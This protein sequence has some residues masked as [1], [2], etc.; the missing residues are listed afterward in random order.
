[1]GRG[2]ACLAL[3]G[4]V[5]SAL[6]AQAAPDA[7]WGEALAAG[8]LS[9]KGAQLASNRPLGAGKYRLPAFEALWADWRG[10]AP[11]AERAADTALGA[12]SLADLARAGTAFLST[13]SGGWGL[14]PG[15]S[16]RVAWPKEGRAALVGAVAALHSQ[17]LSAADQSALTRACAEVPDRVAGAAARLLEAV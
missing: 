8:G 16:A 5:L 6:L 13:G 9:G 12:R 3:A 4:L 14:A 11:A 7:P 15:P 10:L 2:T 17:G 1:M